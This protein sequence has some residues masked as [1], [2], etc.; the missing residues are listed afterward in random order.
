MKISTR[1]LIII[2][3]SLI[4]L[5]GMLAWFFNQAIDKET[6]MF[7]SKYEKSLYEQKQ[8]QL[9][10]ATKIAIAVMDKIY[11]DNIA[12][13]ATKEKITQ[14]IKEKLSKAFYFEDNSGFIFIT[15]EKAIMVFHP[16]L[17]FLEGKNLASSKDKNG[18]LFSQE[19]VKQAKKGGGFTNYLF[20]KKKGGEPKPKIAYTQEFKP[21]KWTVGTSVFVD[22]IEDEITI[23]KKE[24]E[25][26]V[27]KELIFVLS[28]SAISI[29][30]II[31]IS[32]FLI[33]KYM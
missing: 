13:G 26:G 12:K 27:R 16:K 20:A 17:K 31:L 6:N 23:L 10:D 33:K 5:G 21:Y 24:S 32:T 11:Q 19:M 14:E 1:I 9:K 8:A 28:A 3:F 4:L 18:V 7:F 2:S 15:T 29:I 25:E 22:N 30:L